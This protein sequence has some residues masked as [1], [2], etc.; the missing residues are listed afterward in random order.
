MGN[1]LLEKQH[2]N[3][4]IELANAVINLLVLLLEEFAG[5]CWRAGTI[6][7]L[8]TPSKNVFADVSSSYAWYILKN[9]TNQCSYTV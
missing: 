3:N 5:L 9:Q 6:Y 4:E 1:T 2:M 7:F 8:I